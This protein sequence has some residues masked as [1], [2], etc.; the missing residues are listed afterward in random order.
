MATQQLEFPYGS[1]DIQTPAYAATIAATIQNLMT[2]IA[3]AQMTGALTINL[4]LDQGVKAGARLLVKALSDGT[5][6]TVT[7]G[8]GFSN[9]TA[10]TGVIS[11]T[12]AIEFVYDGTGFVPTSAGVQID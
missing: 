5:A 7:W 10:M 4:T 11:K 12:K 1:T 3:P 8:T 2:I 9:A 6:R